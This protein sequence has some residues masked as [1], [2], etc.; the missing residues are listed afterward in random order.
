MAD[1]RTDLERQP[2]L[3]GVERNARLV[4]R[5]RIRYWQD[6]ESENRR[7]KSELMAAQ[8]MIA[9]LIVTAGGEVTISPWTLRTMNL[10]PTL[11]SYED[12]LTGAMIVRVHDA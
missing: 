11:E 2:D 12:V 5:E 4:G 1:T 10:N 9:L 6:C 8:Q 7:L 3:I